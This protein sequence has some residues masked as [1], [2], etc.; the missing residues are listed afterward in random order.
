MHTNQHI[1]NNHV[2]C[3][4]LKIWYIQQWVRKEKWK[5]DTW[6]DKVMVFRTSLMQDVEKQ[7]VEGGPVFVYDRCNNFVR[8]NA[9]DN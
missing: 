3:T 4:G 8:D 2:Y 6:I 7:Q 5:T 1:K 9:T